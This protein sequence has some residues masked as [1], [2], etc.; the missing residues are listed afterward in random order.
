MGKPDPSRLLRERTSCNFVD[1]SEA[2]G[3]LIDDASLGNQLP[4]EVFEMRAT[5]RAAIPA[6]TAVHDVADLGDRSTVR[7]EQRAVREAQSSL[8]HKERSSTVRL[9]V[10]TSIR[11]DE[12]A[13]DDCQR[14][15]TVGIPRREEDS[16]LD[17]GPR[18]ACEEKKQTQDQPLH[19]VTVR[20]LAPIGEARS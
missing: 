13:L 4:G 5:L 8:P 16:A 7:S 9:D 1:H 14:S 11:L 10:H 20:L 12:D 19:V 18:L 15:V 3:T 6:A 2:I 17:A